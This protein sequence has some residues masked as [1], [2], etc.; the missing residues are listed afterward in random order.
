MDASDLTLVEWL[1][2]RFGKWIQDGGAAHDTITPLLTSA[3]VITCSEG[4]VLQ[5]WL[6]TL[7]EQVWSSYWIGFAN[8]PSHCHAHSP[9]NP[10]S[11][12]WQ[13]FDYS[14]EPTVRRFSHWSSQIR[15]PG[16]Q[17][18]NRGSTLEA[19]C[20]HPE[21]KSITICSSAIFLFFTSNLTPSS[22]HY[23][24]KWQSF[25]SYNNESISN[26]RLN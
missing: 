5:H 1:F 20:D 23:I 19:S 4:L 18:C 26:R 16:C 15:T 9:P 2:Y 10:L 17:I 21:L 22:P 12:P 3:P 7:L 6:V 24:I 25:W 14:T 13:Q 8:I 11:P